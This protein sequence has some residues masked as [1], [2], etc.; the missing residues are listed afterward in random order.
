MS[1]TE[2]EGVPCPSR[3]SA[4]AAIEHLRAERDAAREKVKELR[5]NLF[6][7]SEA[8]AE[9][10][11]K[12]IAAQATIAET[13]AKLLGA[14]HYIDCLGGNGNAYRV[15]LPTHQDAL[16]EALARECERLKAHWTNAPHIAQWL[17]E[18]AAAHRAR[19]E[20]K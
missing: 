19:K 5:E 11:R 8:H 16:H 17:D 6:V 13:L 1:A 20:Q 3:K 12:L 10:M 14:S 2:F 9:T 4:R 7:S 18:E 15:T